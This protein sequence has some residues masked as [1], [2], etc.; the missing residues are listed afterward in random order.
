MRDP[1]I[2]WT[3][4]L[5]AEFEVMIESCSKSEDHFEI[6]INTDCLRPAGGG[7]ASDRA[8]LRVG[9][10]V[11]RV[12]DTI[13]A[14]DQVV[15]ICD[16]QFKIGDHAVLTIDIDWR[17]RM[18]Q[19][20]TA[21]HLFAGQ[22]I[23]T[24]EGARLGY[25][26]IDG[27]HGTVDLDDVELTFEQVFAAEREVQRAISEDLEVITE[28][29]TAGDLGPDVRAREGI[30]KKHEMIR[31]VKIPGYDAS[32]CSGTH[33]R[34][35]GEIGFFKVIDVHHSDT[36]TRV[37]F[38]AGQRAMFFVT[39]IFNLAFTRKY[40]Y[41]FEMEQLGAILDKGK[42]AIDGRTALVKTISTILTDRTISE[43]VNGILLRCYY[44]EGMETRDL[45]PLIK[46]LRSDRREVRLFFIP[47]MKSNLTLWTNELPGPAK[48][49]IHKAVEGFGGRGGGSDR[50][51]TGGFTDVERP[52]DL[53][54]RIIEDIKSQLKNL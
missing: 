14:N 44:L 30:T 25:I 2:Y 9:E 54:E 5:R 32:A 21:E 37:E 45:K 36:G 53:F 31:T 51:Y 42:R 27:E 50:V 41:P 12:I 43:E 46:Q 18:M 28:I 15:L 38:L 52:R 39:K 10:T 33:V 40:E 1:P 19:H 26:W 49:I 20:H 11:G 34:R 13:E 35:T 3:D 6:T 16:T 8:I 4:P 47:G 17:K 7:Q 22:I 23:K 29:H 48:S 24:V